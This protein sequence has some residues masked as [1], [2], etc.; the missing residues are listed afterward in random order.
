MKSQVA[1]VVGIGIGMLTAWAPTPVRPGPTQWPR[2][3]PPSCS[4][5]EPCT[6]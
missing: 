5:I 6:A 1:L 3:S 2:L 4:S